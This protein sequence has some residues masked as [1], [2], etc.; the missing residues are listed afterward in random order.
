MAFTCG[1]FNS[2][3]GDRKYNA[4]QMASIF[5]GLIK[6]GVYDTVGEI[7]AVTPGTGMQVLVGS[8]RA[9]FDHTWNNNDASYPLAITAADV[10]LPRYDAVVLETNHSDTVRTNRL[11]VVTG[12]P[13]SNPVKPTM[14]SSAN[15]KQHPL[16]YIKVTAGAK[17]ITQSMIQV[18]VG[19][20]ECPFV[21]GIIDTAEIDAL[22]QQWNGEFNEWF[23]NLKAQLSDNVVANL[24][25]Q[26]DQ[27]VAK[28]DVATTADIEAGTS[29]TKW[30]TPKGLKEAGIDDYQVG[31][32]VNTERT[33]L[34]N[35]YLLCNGAYFDSSEYPLLAK[36]STLNP[37]GTSRILFPTA[38]GDNYFG[39]TQ[40]IC[41]YN[42]LW[43]A[44]GSRAAFYTTDP[45]SA[46]NWIAVYSGI[47]MTITDVSCYNGL[48]VAIGYNNML[49]RIATTTDPTSPNW[50]INDIYGPYKCNKIYCHQGTW[51]AYSTS[52]LT[53]LYTSNPMEEW[54]I[55]NINGS[56]SETIMSI[57]YGNNSWGIL[58]REFKSSSYYT[59][60]L[61]TSNSLSGSWT[62]S[63]LVDNKRESIFALGY[64][65]GTWACGGTKYNSSSSS[66]MPVIYYYQNNKWNNVV[67][68][69]DRD[70]SSQGPNNTVLQYDGK[71]WIFIIDAAY[72]SVNI[73]GPW[74]QGSGIEGTA[75]PYLDIQTGKMCCGYEQANTRISYYTAIN[76]SANTYTIPFP[77]GS[78]SEKSIYDICESNDMCIAISNTYAYYIS[79]K[80]GSSFKYSTVSIK[81]VCIYYYNG[82][83]VIGGFEGS[84]PYYPCVCVSNDAKQ[85]TK[86]RV[87]NTDGRIY[88]IY[89]YN[90]LWVAISEKS[91]YTSSNPATSWT[92]IDGVGGN[93][94]H[95][96]NGT[97]AIVNSNAAKIYVSTSPSGSWVSKNVLYRPSDIYCYN[98]LW[99]APGDY[100]SA[101]MHSEDP[102]G[103]WKTNTSMLNGSSGSEGYYHGICSITCYEGMWVAIG[104]TA[105]GSGALIIFTTDDPTGVWN[106][107]QSSTSD[108][109]PNCVRNIDGLWILGNA[110]GINE[111]RFRLPSISD[112]TYYSY[113]K[114]K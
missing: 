26:I 73:S 23:E 59:A 17:A 11:R 107:Y 102:F 81:C 36:T 70:A 42:G 49:T 10:S 76:V 58:T 50:T 79:N 69:E 13:A 40:A 96:Y 30:V 82:L 68:R 101:F 105:R 46:N 19:T 72:A 112:N 6:D 113:I 95:C 45:S 54:T 16:A 66:N 14:T 98:G 7:F 43:V 62:A 109:Q 88:D 27:K 78:S 99:V 33:D 57:C 114:A 60:R 90:G 85:W 61:Y 77:G 108:A 87:D 93:R 29:T 48:W 92:K 67:V 106:M 52:S 74:N 55:S 56:S 34:G 100:Y 53:F 91:I 22:F 21:T 63:I 111:L 3:N 15:V 8:G 38:N 86:V 18:V 51:I 5:D 103:E 64:G 83:W 25:G 9:W 28:A 41:A 97:W 75:F 110:L 84:S 89:C 1:F 31:D 47:D 94:V 104:R 71:K 32:I 35:D 80:I 24:Q 65:N 37:H 39:S 20:S 12:T 2:Q 44:M 4:E